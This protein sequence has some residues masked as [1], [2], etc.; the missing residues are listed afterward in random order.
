MPFPA[1]L[2]WGAAAA[3]GAYGV[4]KGVDAYN[5]FERAKKIGECAERRYNKANADLETA[6]T[7]AS[8]ELVDLGR[9]KLEVF[10]N[11]IKYIVDVIKRRSKGKAWSKIEGFCEDFSIE[12]LRQ[13][14]KAIVELDTIDVGKEILLK[15]SAASFLMGLGAYGSLGMFASASTGAAIAT[16]SSASFVAGGYAL[17]A[18]SGV[19]AAS[20]GVAAAVG[21]GGVL[22]TGSAAG[23]AILGG[24]ILTPVLAIGAFVFSAKAEE[25]MTEAKKYESDVDKA[26]AE[27]DRINTNIDGIV[28]AK[29][30][31]YSTICKLASRFDACKVDEYASD[32]AFSKMLSIGK[33]L[34]N[35][36]DV[37]I[38]D[39]EGNYDKHIKAKCEGLC[40]YVSD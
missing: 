25:A 1:L 11:Q 22:A 2:L 16:L 29:K 8:Q 26:C 20:S 27:I 5:D 31:L 7:Y 32:A 15:S 40:K 23:M 39:E 38:L 10:K 17:A 3:I 9:L 19:V 28:R 18:S 12:D 13:C 6:R 34:K 36:L 37:A 33:V 24:A 21:G 4:K 14:E 35:A 30:E